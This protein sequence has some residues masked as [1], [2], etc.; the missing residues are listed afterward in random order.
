MIDKQ[1]EKSLLQQYALEDNYLKL[2]EELPVGILSCDREGNIVYVNRFLLNLMGSPSAEKSKSRINMLSSPAIIESGISAPIRKTLENGTINTIEI[3][4]YSIWGK[5]LFMHL[6]T[7]PLH[8]STGNII[9]CCCIVEDATKVIE[10]KEALERKLRKEKLIS[11]ISSRLINSTLNE[12]DGEIRKALGEVA[13]FL[14]AHHAVLYSDSKSQDCMTRTYGWNTQNIASCMGIEETVKNNKWASEQFHR[15]AIID[16]PDLEEFNDEGKGIKESLR[17]MDIASVLVVPLYY[18]STFKGF[19]EINTV[20]EKRQWNESGIYLVKLVGEMITSLLERK[21]TESRL[22]GKE[23]DYRKLVTSIDTLIWRTDIDEK[24]NYIN[25]QISA[26]A[27]KVLGLPETT[28]HSW[29]D[30]FACIH[31]EDKD[32]LFNI[33]QYTV[34]HA[35]VTKNVDYRLV[36]GDGSIQWV[37]STGTAYVLENGNVQ[38][39]GTAR[40]ITKQKLAEEELARSEKR[41]RS[42]VEQSSDGI[43]INRTD[44]QIVEVNSKACEIMGYTK[45]QLKQMSVVDLL[46]P[47]LRPEGEKVMELLKVQ[48]FI[49]GETKYLT[50]KGD[51]IDVEINASLLDGYRDIT[52]AV[53]RDITERKRAEEAMLRAKVEAESANRI[54][55]EF[56][57]SMSH[58][59]RTPL[60]SIIGF[61]DMLAEGYAGP[62]SETQQKYT[63][64][65]STSGKYLL[66]L[67]NNILDIAKIESGKM[68]L[69]LEPF[70]MNEVFED[71]EKLTGHLARKKKIELHVIKP[72]NIELLADKIKVKQIIY[73]LLSNAIKFTPDNG[74]VALS[75]TASGNKVRVSVTDTGI[76]IAESD[77]DKLFMPFKQINSQLSRQY[78][79]SGLGLSIVKE[80][81][82][83]H[84]GN[85]TVESEPGKGSTFSFTIPFIPP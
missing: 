81:V 73:N 51:I 46:I 27:D 77:F 19:L 72:E 62:L 6:K 79:G 8:D 49:H 57:A 3:P 30:Y 63:N 85:V 18:K 48:S 35:G 83:L 64:Y 23:E 60:N 58:E 38:L 39:L 33:I 84:G 10:A 31:P 70:N 21:Y 78:S 17:K 52:Q 55:S 68:E 71:A 36:C 20:G 11:H 29:D 32:E 37:N 26:P 5:S 24:W 9:G 82:E 76:G 14:D 66:T 2:M 56:L 69:E 65:I 53:V 16:I 40:N 45:E 50:G 15:R 43:F 7:T 4:Y 67:I 42:L 75:A 47:E 25:P 22:I 12:I 28:I 80:L 74:R 41:Y 59:L 34:L 44:G 54:K 1:H 13:R 61:S